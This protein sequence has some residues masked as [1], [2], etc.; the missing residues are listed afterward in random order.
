MWQLV[1]VVVLRGLLLL[2]T[3]LV[4]GIGATFRGFRV[5]E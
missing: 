4:V 2:G 5:A 3:F 1:T